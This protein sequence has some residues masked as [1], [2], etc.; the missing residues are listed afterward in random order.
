MTEFADLRAG[1]WRNDDCTIFSFK[2]LQVPTN[3]QLGF[4]SIYCEESDSVAPS[5]A[6]SSM[7]TVPSGVFGQ[8]FCIMRW[9]GGNLHYHTN[10]QR[11]V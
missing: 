8:N 5:K 9:I 11:C 6:R 7:L 10:T 2:A 1:A 3:G 4:Y